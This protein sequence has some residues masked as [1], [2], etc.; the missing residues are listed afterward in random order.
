MFRKKNRAQ[1]IEIAKM[2]QQIIDKKYYEN[3]FRVIRNNHLIE[4]QKLQR[5][6]EKEVDREKKNLKE[7]FN[8]RFREKDYKIIALKDK[9]SFLKKE[10]LNYKKAYKTYEALRYHLLEISNTTLKIAEGL[11][12]KA[13]NIY[14]DITQIDT[15]IQVHVRKME[16]LG[17]KIE[18]TMNIESP[19]EKII[20]NG[21]ER[22]KE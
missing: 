6:K 7:K 4:I 12:D 10:L 13:S 19:L 11:R 21:D 22:K 16:K 8:I 9:I 15:G 14:K 20:R 17:P 5:E 18:K 1:E 2:R 3:N